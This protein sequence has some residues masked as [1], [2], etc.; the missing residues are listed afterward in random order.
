MTAAE[1]LC[2][3]EIIIPGTRD[4]DVNNFDK[5][6]QFCL[7]HWVKVKEMLEGKIEVIFFPLHVTFSSVCLHFVFCLL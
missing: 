6:T 1:I 7:T 3:K 2:P 4:Q 5:E